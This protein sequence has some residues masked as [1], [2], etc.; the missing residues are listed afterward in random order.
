MDNEFNRAVPQLLGLVG[1]DAR[2]DARFS[3]SIK[4]EDVTSAMHAMRHP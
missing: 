2:R 3:F 4:R 1:R